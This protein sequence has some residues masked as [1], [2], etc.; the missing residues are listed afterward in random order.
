[1]QVSASMTYLPSPAEIAETGHSLSQ[2][3]QEIHSSEITY[4]MK[5]HLLYKL[6]SLYHI[7]QKNQP[8]ISYLCFWAI[9]VLSF[10][11][12]FAFLII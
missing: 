7:P 2:V 3:P 6:S 12:P 8:E 1:M 5:E 10:A 11:H 9:L 4:A